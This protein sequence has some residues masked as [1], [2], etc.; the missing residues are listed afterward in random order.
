MFQLL[1]FSHCC[2]TSL[3][4]FFWFS[5]LDLI[6]SFR[7][8]T[9]L[10]YINHFVTIRLVDSWAFKI[11]HHCIVLIPVTKMALLLSLQKLEICIDLDCQEAKLLPHKL[12]FSN[13]TEQLD[14][15][16]QSL[17]VHKI[18]HLEQYWTNL[19]ATNSSLSL[20]ISIFWKRIISLNSCLVV[21][22]V[23]SHVWTASNH[24]FW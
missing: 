18:T 6:Q 1:S 4:N 22:V 15:E 10:K 12:F 3:D 9:P 16:R 19:P 8:Q 13:A 5:E 23:F 7:S 24:I 20:Y 14:S 21:V 2:K 11:L 17:T